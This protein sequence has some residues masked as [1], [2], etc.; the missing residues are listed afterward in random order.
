MTSQMRLKTKGG[1]EEDED[2]INVVNSSGSLVDYVRKKMKNA[3][4]KAVETATNNAKL[5]LDYLSQ[6]SKN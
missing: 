6:E 5:K 4:D 3:I 2:D 1:E